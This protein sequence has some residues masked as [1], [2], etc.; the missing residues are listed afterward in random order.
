MA[1]LKKCIYFLSL[2][3]C[4]ALFLPAGNYAAHYRQSRMGK[5]HYRIFSD[6]FNRLAPGDLR[7]LHRMFSQAHLHLYQRYGITPPAGIEVAITL[8]PALFR[9][10]TGRDH[11]HGAVY[12]PRRKGF[13]FFS[14]AAL[15]ASR[16]LEILTYRAVLH[17]LI[18]RARRGKYIPGSIW[19]DQA[20][21][22][23]RFPL[24]KK[25]KRPP[26]PAFKS[27]RDFRAYLRR[28]LSSKNFKEKKTAIIAAGL[29]GNHMI[30]KYGEKFLLERI[31][32]GK[33]TSWMGDA[34]DAFA[35]NLK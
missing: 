10:I 22:E 35:Q 9:D 20:F 26:L 34:C 14:P 21:C 19:M 31:I 1:P 15:R 13:C 11:R 7:V 23:A 24:F 30:K 25:D 29:W 5:V 12:M 6:N 33:M 32:R 2:L 8:T 4:C 28:V 18:H 16:R 27:C 17:S 3:I